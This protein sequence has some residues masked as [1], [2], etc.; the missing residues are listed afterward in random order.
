M[1]LLSK[2]IGWRYWTKNTIYTP[3]A[4]G[5]MLHG[6]LRHGKIFHVTLANPKINMAGLAEDSKYQI[7]QSIPTQYIPSTVFIPKDETWEFL[8]TQF[9]EFKLEFP[10]YAKPDIGEGGMAVQKITNW[11]HLQQYYQNHHV[12]FIL[13]NTIPYK[14]EFGIMIHDANGKVEINSLTERVHFTLIGDG[15]STISNLIYAN[16]SYRLRSKKILSTMGENGERVLNNGEIF[17]P[18][19]LG[20]WGYGATFLDRRDCITPELTRLFQELNDRIGLF[21]VGRYDVLTPSLEALLKGEFQIIEINGLKAE[22]IHVFDPKFNFITAYRE[23]IQHW[24]HVNKIAI[25]NEK[26]GFAALDFTTA[27]N[28]MKNHFRNRRNPIPQR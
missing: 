7:Y 18:I 27:K 20:N 19:A 25:R 12:D 9:S 26:M 10:I 11:A 23:I 14:K 1:S 21:H 4:L 6:F 24:R 22:L 5:V 17:Q 8:K 16:K 28:H 13:Q 15:Q 2:T 3:L